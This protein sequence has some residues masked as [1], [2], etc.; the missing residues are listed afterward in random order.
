MADNNINKVFIDEDTYVEKMDALIASVKNFPVNYYPKAE[1]DAKLAEKLSI[2]SNSSGSYV[3]INEIDN[4]L[5]N[6]LVRYKTSEKKVVLGGSTLPTTIM[7]SGDRPNYSKDGSNFTGAPLALK[8]D[9]DSASATLSSSISSIKTSITT[10]SDRVDTLAEVVNEMDWYGIQHQVLSG[11]APTT[12][13]TYDKDAGQNGTVISIDW[14]HQSSSTASTASYAMDFNVVLHTAKADA[15]AIVILDDDWTIDGS[16]YQTSVTDES[17]YDTEVGTEHTHAANVMYLESEYTLPFTD[18]FDAPEALLK[19]ASGKTLPAGSYYIKWHCSDGTSNDIYL[20]F[21]LSS[22]VAAGHQLRL[23]ANQFWGGAM[24]GNTIKEYSDGASTTAIQTSTAMAQ[25][26]TG[27]YLGTVWGNTTYG[28]DGAMNGYLEPETNG[29][30]THYINHGDRIKMGYSRWSQ[31][32]LRQYL[33]A[34]GFGWWK[35]M[36]P[37]DVAPSYQNYRGFMSGLDESLR[38]VIVPIRRY[39]RTNYISDIGAYDYTYDK[40]F[41]RV[42]YEYYTATESNGSKEGSCTRWPYYKALLDKWNADNGTSLS[43]FALWTTYSILKKYSISSKTSAQHVW[44]SSARRT[45]GCDVWGVRPGGL[46][47]GTYAC[48]TYIV[49]CPAFVISK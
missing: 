36:S 20:T 24:I 1:I 34:E 4:T 33:N 41:L 37:F 29:G 27:T 8:S 31:S 3:Q 15:G 17:K 12:M 46:V 16:V 42:P 28:T 21:T 40:V 22:A 45:R 43:Q 6:A 13:P 11:E 48:A 44:S 32:G 19:V 9:V 47:D 49:C 26:Q 7:G 38:K 18:Q 35:P 25:G 14:S 30:V 10:L 5:G 2:L 23:G 39:Q